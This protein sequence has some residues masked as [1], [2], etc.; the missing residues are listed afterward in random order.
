M[1]LLDF[2]KDFFDLLAT[3]EIKLL[4]MFSHIITSQ[5]M[6]FSIRDFFSKCNQIRW[7][8]GIWSHLQKKPLIEIFIFLCSACRT[9]VAKGSIYNESKKLCYRNKFEFISHQQIIFSHLWEDALCEKCPY[10]ELFWSKSWKIWTKITPNTYKSKK[11][12]FMH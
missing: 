12:F 5:K 4:L 11:S 7:K 1:L 2:L 3:A 9:L 10:L 8:L 6:E